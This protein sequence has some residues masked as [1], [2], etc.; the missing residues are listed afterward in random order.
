M[1]ESPPRR[2]SIRLNGYDYS[3]AGAYFITICSY[4][5]RCIFG[6]IIDARTRLSRHGEIL[7]AEWLRSGEIRPHLSLDAFVVMPNHV[8]GIVLIEPVS[9]PVQFAAQAA[10][11]R[12]TQPAGPR[13]ASIGSFVGGFKAAVTRR[14]NAIGKPIDT[15]V[16]QRNYYEHIIRSEARL[17]AIREYIANNPANWAHDRQNPG[18]TRAQKLAANWQV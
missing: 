2:R 15:P 7:Q 17:S 18:T 14:I 11:P 3:Q 16:W 13:A 1:Q 12:R 4:Q 8:H 10:S 6:E 9:E 5:R